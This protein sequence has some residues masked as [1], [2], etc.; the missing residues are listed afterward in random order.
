MPLSGLRPAL[1]AAALVALSVALAGCETVSKASGGN[2]AEFVDD[3]FSDASGA[4]VAGSCAVKGGSYRSFDPELLA[5]TGPK[6]RAKAD[7]TERK[8]EWGF[9]V[10][11][12]FVK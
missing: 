8:P 7:R 9:R 2:V 3:E 10:L 12:E 6:S 4:K 11:A 5:A 1:I